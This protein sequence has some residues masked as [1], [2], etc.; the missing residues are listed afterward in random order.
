MSDREQKLWPF[1]PR[2]S[3]VAAVLIL[4]GLL[5][6]LV[7]LRVRLDWPSPESDRT[8]SEGHRRMHR[9]TAGHHAAGEGPDINPA[10]I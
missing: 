8:V 7:I 3:I 5:L 10:G 6:T 4:F 1:E 2:T 9:Q